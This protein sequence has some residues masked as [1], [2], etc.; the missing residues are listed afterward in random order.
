[1][2][3]NLLKI[4]LDNI[5]TPHQLSEKFD[6]TNVIRRPEHKAQKNRI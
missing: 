2:E 4:I 6:P 5:I 3:N 1:M